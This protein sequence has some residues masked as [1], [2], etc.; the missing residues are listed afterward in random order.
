MKSYTKL[1]EKLEIKVNKV[2]EQ[3]FRNK[4]MKNVLGKTLEAKKIK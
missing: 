1:L 4:I 3:K 2:L